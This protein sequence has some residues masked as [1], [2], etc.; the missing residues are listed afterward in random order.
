MG[1]LD[2][3]S[4]DELLKKRKRG[5]NALLRRPSHRTGINHIMTSFT[6]M[7]TTTL[8]FANRKCASLCFSASRNNEGPSYYVDFPDDFMSSTKSFWS[9]VEKLLF[10]RAEDHSVLYGAWCEKARKWFSR[11]DYDWYLLWPSYNCNG[12]LTVIFCFQGIAELSAS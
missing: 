10:F 8:L 7:T 3:Q 4:I 2:S 11:Y 1:S 6:S 5:Q 9:D 12:Y